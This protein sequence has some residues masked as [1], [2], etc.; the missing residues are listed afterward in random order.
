MPV[1]WET[2][3]K[4]SCDI[5]APPKPSAISISGRAQAQILR[6]DAETNEDDPEVEKLRGTVGEPQDAGSMRPA[7]DYG[8]RNTNLSEELAPWI[9]T[10]ERYEENQIERI[11]RLIEK[12]RDPDYD[13]RIYRVRIG[14]GVIDGVGGTDSEMMTEIRGIE[15]V[16][17]VRPLAETKRK[18]N[19]NENYTVFEI[20]FE[21]LGAR[22]RIKYRDYFLIPQMRK[23]EG[24][25]II[26]WSAIHK[27]NIQGS[28]RTVREGLE[29]L[30][31]QGWGTA[32]GMGSNF[33]GSA[34][35]GGLSNVRYDRR[36]RVTPTPT[37][38]SI[39]DDWVEGGVQAYDFPTN[40]N[41]MQYHTMLPVKE[42]WHHR[43][44]IQRHP[45]DIYDIKYQ[46]FD[47]VYQR[48]KDT[49]KD[50][51]RYQ[52]FIRDGAH[53]PVYLAIGQNGRIKLTGNEDLVWF[54]KQ[55]G[56][57]ELPVFISYQRQV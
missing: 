40:T 50:P 53:G 8:T 29:K 18:I 34:L 13:L 3:V 57:K 55:A 22:N 5:A 7:G 4:K 16:S 25:R 49:L 42:L 38:D 19:P 24:L 23:I 11:Q 15:G 32:Y 56:L 46:Q 31:E 21:L 6:R 10:P 51:V 36:A 1:G 47:A 20:K 39:K 44:R 26:D 35:A 14:C 45:K 12:K 2:D 30:N 37:L 54:A 33:G 52:E 9:E 27:T 28:I 43:S 41:D 48:L 17:T